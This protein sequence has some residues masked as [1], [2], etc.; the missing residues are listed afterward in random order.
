MK[1]NPKV[2]E[3]NLNGSLANGDFDKYSDIDIKVDVSGYD[4]GK[5][6]LM[7][8]DI[9]KEIY[10]VIYTAF[11]P[12]LLPY[13]YV[14][15]FAFSKDD[16]FSFI[17]F[18]CIATPHMSAVTIDEARKHNGKKSLFLKLS[19]ANTKHFLR[20]ENCHNDILTI[21]SLVLNVDE[22]QDKDDKEILICTLN[23][24]EQNCEYPLKDMASKCRNY[25]GFDK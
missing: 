17:D 3:C 8:P 1:E 6:M 24:L 16:I 7:P 10:N 5:F 14:V 25:L 22:I 19:I 20:N 11:A 9:I 4:N 15:S 12:G 23:R 18:E 13:V 21:A 2:K